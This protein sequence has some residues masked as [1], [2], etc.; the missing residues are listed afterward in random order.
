MNPK[1]R[2]FSAIAHEEPDRVPVGEWQFGEEIARA[3]LGKEPLFFN[4]LHTMQAFW[5]GRRDEVIDQWKKGLVEIVLKLNWDAVLVHQ[6]IDKGAVIDVPK[7]VA[8][9]KW[10]YANG[11]ISQYSRETNRLFTIQGGNPHENTEKTITEPTDSQL[12]VVRYVKK[13]LGDTHFIFSAA[14]SAPGPSMRAPAGEIKN[15]VERWCD[16]YEDPDAWLE[17][18]MRAMKSEITRKGIETARREGM[19]GVA[20]GCDYGGTTGPF[21]S[22]DLF[23]KAI[24]P[25]LACYTELVHKNG[26]VML[27]H[28]CGNNQILMD[29]IVEAGIDVYQS[30]QT[31]MDIVKMKK[32]YG[33]NI[34]LWGGVP[35]GDLILSTPAEIEECSRHYLEECKG[36]G[37]YI[38]ATS[39]SIMPGAKYENYTA[40]LNAHKKY[41]NY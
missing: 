39:H 27:L 22:P 31:E 17:N 38:F 24:L 25:G 10:L 37:G 33:K 5:D 32:R 23:R 28:S 8:E 41:G 19:D 15:E 3:V 26:M 12:E 21:M 2:M 34:T 29:M 11:A 7:Q 40:M 36:G 20:Y 30:I 6:V 16:L 4:G 18:T 14:L 35:A 9:D 1:E 13:E